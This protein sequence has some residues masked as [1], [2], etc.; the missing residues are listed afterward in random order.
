MSLL[1]LWHGVLK[2]VLSNQ[3]VGRTYIEG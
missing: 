1:F 3:N 2:L